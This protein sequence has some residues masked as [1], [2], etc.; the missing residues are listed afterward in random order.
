VMTNEPATSSGS[1]VIGAT[2]IGG[3]ATST[4]SVQTVGTEETVGTKETPSRGDSSPSRTQVVQTVQLTGTAERE[5][6]EIG[7][8][9]VAAAAGM[10][11]LG[12]L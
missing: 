4:N 12:V 6:G 10:V 9:G 1:R 2:S 5:R 11:I 7:I 8:G 3:G